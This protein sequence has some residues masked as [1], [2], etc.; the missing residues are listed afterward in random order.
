MD[1]MTARDISNNTT[2]SDLSPRGPVVLVTI[3]LDTE[4]GE[5]LRDFAASTPLIRLRAQRGFGD[6]N[7]NADWL[8]VPSPDICLLDFDRD[9]H[10]AARGA[11]RIHASLPGVAVVAV[12]SQNDPGLI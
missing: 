3:G 4:T 11:E 6:D 12:S 5:F 1:P 7:S 10:S 2:S 9:R 8:G